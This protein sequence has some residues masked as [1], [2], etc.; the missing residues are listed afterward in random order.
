[1][2]INR[3]STRI[4]NNS[5]NNTCFCE[6]NLTSSQLTEVMHTLIHSP[7]SVSALQFQCE[8]NFIHLI[9]TLKMKNI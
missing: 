2:Q 7:F 5:V 3:I 1:M 9:H 8:R 4:V 6:N